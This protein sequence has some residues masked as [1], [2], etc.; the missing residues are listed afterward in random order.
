MSIKAVFLIFVAAVIL[1]AC[2]GQNVTKKDRNKG[3]ANLEQASL[4]NVQLGVGYLKR[5]QYEIAQN[6][7]EKAIE[8]NPD[9]V[10]AYTTM[11]FL[12]MQINMMDEAEEYYLDALDIREDDPELINGYGT[13]LCRTE[14]VDEAMAQ[15]EK[16]Y[17]NPFYKTRFLAYSNAGTCLLQAK[18]YGLAEDMLRRA[19]K[20]KPD[21][22]DALLSMAELAVKTQKFMMARAYIQRFHATSRASAESLWVQVQA[23]KALG[24]NEHYQ[25]YAR[26]LLEHFSDS[27]QA[28]L[29]EEMVRR[30]QIRLY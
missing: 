18:R 28:G 15:F 21:L 14:R 4:T 26:Q 9:N 19:L 13:Y 6:K 12:L 27:E 2:G 30:D 22:P 11:A 25:K 10:V 23:E 1:P 16:A 3:D 29:V 7:L 8:Q 17:N 20:S 24:A 5:G